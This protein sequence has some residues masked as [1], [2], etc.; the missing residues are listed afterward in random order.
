MFAF[1]PGQHCSDV[2]VLAIKREAALLVVPGK[3]GEAPFDGRDGD[4]WSLANWSSHIRQIKS[5]HLWRGG[6]RVRA[7]DPTPAPKVFPVG[8]VGFVGVFGC[9]GFGVVARGI[10]KAIK[11]ARPGHMRWQ[12]DPIASLLISLVVLNVRMR[13]RVR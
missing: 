8:R 13:I 12:G 10:N 11:R 5:D 7:P 6:Q 1:D 4:C 9:G 3:T 2:T